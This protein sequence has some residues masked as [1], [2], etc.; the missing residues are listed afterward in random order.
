MEPNFIGIACVPVNGSL[1]CSSTIG[2]IIR[3]II[4]IFRP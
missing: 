4:S 3:G 2:R 1:E